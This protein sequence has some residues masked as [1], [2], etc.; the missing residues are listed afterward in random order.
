M[1]LELLDLAIGDLIEGYHFYER[2]EAG[3]GT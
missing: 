2:Q 1:K 3:L